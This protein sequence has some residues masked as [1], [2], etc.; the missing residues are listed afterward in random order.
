M[1][2]AHGEPVCR[3]A[4]LEI[5][6]A[7]LPAYRDLLKE[8]IEASQEAEPGVLML[9]ALAIKGSPTHLRIFEIY[10]D[11]EAYEAHL[12]APHFLKYKALT[13]GMVRSLRLIEADPVVLR[14]KAGPPTP[15]AG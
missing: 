9:Y 6:P 10:A 7:H 8:E 5:D 2:L 12:S 11:Q 1:S 13:S 3:I 14:A 15:P 4:E